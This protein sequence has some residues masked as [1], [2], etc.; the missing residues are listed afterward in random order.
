MPEAAKRSRQSRGAN[1]DML[2]TSRQGASTRRGR[3][4]GQQQEGPGALAGAAPINAT[5]VES[6]PVQ[7][8]TIKLAHLDNVA[9][10]RKTMAQ[11]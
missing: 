7:F 5:A 4:R 8:G 3:R 6:V 10:L 1:D 11:S 9:D 2:A